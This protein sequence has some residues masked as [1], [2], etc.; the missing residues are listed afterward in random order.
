M[1]RDI[2]EDNGEDSYQELRYSNEEM[3]KHCDNSELDGNFAHETILE[4]LY[5]TV[6]YRIIRMD[7][8][9]TRIGRILQ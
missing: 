5:R 7:V 9:W 8:R 3:L 2:P 4:W 1:F 6:R